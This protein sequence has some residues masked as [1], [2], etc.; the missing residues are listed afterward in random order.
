M[1]VAHGLCWASVALLLLSGWQPALAQESIFQDDFEDGDAQGWDLESGWSVAV[2]DGNRVLAGKGHSWARGTL[3]LTDYSRISFRLRVLKGRANLVPRL[4][5]NGRYYI[6][7]DANGSSMNKDSPPG[8]FQEDLIGR[9]QW[10]APETWYTVEIVLQGGKIEFLVNGTRQWFYSDPEPLSG[11]RIAF[12][13]TEDSE[14]YVDDVVIRTGLAPVAATPTFGVRVTETAL[15]TSTVQPTARPADTET[16][17]SEFSWSKWIWS[18]V[19]PGALV[20]PT[21]VLA[22]GGRSG[23]R[24][25]L[26]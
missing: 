3:E 13:S 25:S 5:K 23:K 10:H 9:G 8:S 20:I 7:F 1:R 2:V 19:C 6:G 21:S 22:A 11:G 26:R 17:A 12:V 24:R 16:P 15:A 18:L 4:N 14:V